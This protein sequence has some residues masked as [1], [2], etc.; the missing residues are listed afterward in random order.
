[1]AVQL[2]LCQTWFET[3]KTGLLE[4]WLFCCFFHAKAQNIAMNMH[5]IH[6]TFLN[7]QMVN[8]LCVL[9]YF[10]RFPTGSGHSVQSQIRLLITRSYLIRVYIIGYLVSIF[11][12]AF[13]PLELLRIFRVVNVK[14]N[15]QAKKVC[16]SGLSP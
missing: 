2:S 12:K 11:W 10:L 14:A 13:L 1:M 16:K 4:M 8:A 3:Q 9:L 15:F 5:V 6:K 7:K